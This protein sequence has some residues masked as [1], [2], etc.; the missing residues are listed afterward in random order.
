[1]ASLAGAK[2]SGRGYTPHGV[3]AGY[4]V[5]LLVLGLVGYLR[6][7]T[8][9][10]DYYLAGRGQGV[11][12]TSLTIMATMFSSAAMLGIPGLVYRDGASFLPATCIPITP[13]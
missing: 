13:K 1:M 7:K 10:E 6:S 4:M 9:E 12:V 2:Q 11:I 8:T 5:L 3:L